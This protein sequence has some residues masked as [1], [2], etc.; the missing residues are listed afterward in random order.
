MKR[1]LMLAIAI[2]APS[3]ALAQ[4]PTYSFSNLTPAPPSLQTL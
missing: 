2:L 3:A 4:G 1:I